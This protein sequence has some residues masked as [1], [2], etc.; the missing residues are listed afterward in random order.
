MTDKQTYDRLKPIIN[1]IDKTV[2]CQSVTDNG[3]GTYTFLCNKTKWAIPSFDISIL[4]NDYRIVEVD[5][6]VSIKVSGT[7]LPSVLTFD[8][9]VPIFKHGTIRVVASELNK[10]TNHLERLPLIYLKEQITEKLHFDSLDTLDSEPDVTLY[11]LTQCDNS[12][13]TQEDG[14]TKGIAPMRSLA[15]EFIKV[16]ANNQYV[17]PLTST[18]DLRNYNI[19]GNVQDN[20]TNKNIFNEPLAGVGLRIT[21]PFLKE[22]DCCINPALDTRPAPGYVIDGDGNVLAVLYSNE[23]Y[24]STGGVCAGVT[25]TDQ[26]DNILSTVASGGNY[27]ITVLTEI[28]DTIDGNTSTIIDNLN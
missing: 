27:D 13:W 11:F 16:L 10:V 15:N 14:D 25:I 1:L 24:V 4:G 9:Y 21:I 7:V 28:R 19:F 8:L 18:G 3:D 22:C 6:N 17:A 5:Y 2:T 23:Y 26:F 20:G 12:N